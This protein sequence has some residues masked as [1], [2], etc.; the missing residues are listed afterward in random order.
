MTQEQFFEATKFAM[1]RLDETDH[2]RAMKQIGNREPLPYDVE[3]KIAD[4]MDEW[5]SDNGLDPNEWRDIANEEEIFLT[6]F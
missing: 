3:D 5:C 1:D 2:A 4:G 6:T